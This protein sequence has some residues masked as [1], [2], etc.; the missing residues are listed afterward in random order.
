MNPSRLNQML[1]MFGLQAPDK[2]QHAVN[3]VRQAIKRSPAMKR[4]AA[5]Y[6]GA[7]APL[8]RTGVKSSEQ[9]WKELAR[10]QQD[11]HLTNQYAPECNRSRVAKADLVLISEQYQTRTQSHGTLTYQ[12]AL[13]CGLGTAPTIRFLL[14]AER[15]ALSGFGVQG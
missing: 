7:K 14:K 10:G 15:T 8:I 3:A 11:S 9:N 6:A 13:P 4:K 2:R 5:Y 12:V 1:Q